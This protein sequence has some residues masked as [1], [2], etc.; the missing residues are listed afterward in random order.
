[1][2]RN[3]KKKLLNQ[4]V[5]KRR[6]PRFHRGFGRYTPKRAWSLS[7]ARCTGS[8]HE[9]SGA[10]CQDWA[11]SAQLDDITV[12][13]SLSD[14]AGS[15]KLSHYGSSLVATRAPKLI[16][17]HFDEAFGGGFA[18]F[19]QKLVGQLQIEIRSLAKIG[20]D[21]PDEERARLGLPSREKRLLVSCDIRDLS[22]TMLC[23]VV[24]GNRYIAAHVGDGVIGIE[25]ETNGIR[26]LAVVSHPDNGEFANE[27]RFVTS[28]SAAETIRVSCGRIE[29]ERKR[30]TGF[31][32]MSD[33]PEAS[34]YNK[35]NRS[36]GAACSKL[37]EASRQL[38]PVEMSGQLAVTLSDVIAKKTSD[39]CS[40]ALM[41]VCE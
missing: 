11:V 21:P 39:D 12:V 23:V 17:E 3:L 36:L 28:A 37:L 31:I 14:G 1:M 25:Y 22:C 7:H 9:A 19:G 5:A 26:K 29:S 4:A 33:G 10:P 30:T 20:I 18:E 32:L 15:A 27:T 38:D 16:A 6:S 40:I 24:R 35:R 13:I 2:G 41:A 8:S 34:L